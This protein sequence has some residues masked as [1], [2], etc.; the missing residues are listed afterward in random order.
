M[1]LLSSLTVFTPT[2]VFRVAFW[3][4]P[5]E[6]VGIPDNKSIITGVDH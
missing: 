6:L 3:V 5:I 4:V 2:V 1:V